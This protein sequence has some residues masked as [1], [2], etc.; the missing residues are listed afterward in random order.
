MP[1]NVSAVA[2]KRSATVSWTLGSD[3]GSPLTGQTVRVYA[4][5]TFAGTVAV[6]ASATS[7]KIGGLAAGTGYT[8]SVTATNAAG[9]SAESVRSNE[10]TPRR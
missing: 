1:T 3:G 8:F 6:S 2:G 4:A 7:V 10:V 5:G 9:T